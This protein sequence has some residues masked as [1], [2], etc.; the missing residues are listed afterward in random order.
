M[1]IF[2]NGFNSYIVIGYMHEYINSEQLEIM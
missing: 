2:M 1:A